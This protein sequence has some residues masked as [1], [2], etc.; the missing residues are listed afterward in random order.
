[1]N[2]LLKISRIVV[3]LVV[4]GFMATG[5]T[6]SVWFIPGVD[7]FLCDI[8]LGSA[9]ISMSLAVFA[10]WI[11]LTLVFG[12]IYCS[13]VCPMGTLMDISSE[14]VR[15][16]RRGRKRVY[17]YEPPS[18]WVR[19][20]FLAVAVVCLLMGFI[21]LPSVLDPYA[22]FCRVCAGFFNPMLKFFIKELG[23]AGVYSHYVALSI[24]TSVAASIIATFL[25]AVTVT[26]AMVSGRTICST[27][28][29]VGTILGMVS[30]FSIFQF[31]IDTD[32][33]TNCRRCEY[34]CKAH[35]INLDD[36]VVDGSR[37]VVCFDCVNACRDKAIRYTTD[38]KRLSA[39]LM[40]R[41]KNPGR[42]T[43]PT[44]DSVD[45]LTKKLKK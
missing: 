26:M 27:V 7:N 44:F 5:L 10:F 43:E 28:C 19:Y 9:I 21:L 18:T 1:M 30:R 39:P 11:L 29:P 36:H 20:G 33:C 15:M 42:Q 2:K 8:Q 14:S 24:T 25:F 13:T 38:R 34:A 37:C 6:C 16:V 32:L 3:S 17:R 40:Q 4:F 35:C 45:N 23:Q 22:A 31:D 12:R 41:I